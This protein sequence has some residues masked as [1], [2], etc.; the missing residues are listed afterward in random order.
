MYDQYP[1]MHGQC[2]PM[3][4]HYPTM[5][6]QCPP[7]YGQCPPMYGQ[8]PPMHGQ[9]PPLVSTRYPPQCSLHLSSRQWDC[10]RK[11][12]SVAMAMRVWKCTT[13]T[14]ALWSTTSHT[15]TPHSVTLRSVYCFIG[16]HLWWG[17]DNWGELLL[18]IYIYTN[19]FLE[20]YPQVLSVSTH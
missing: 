1:P 11:Q 20:L 9:Y 8:Y 16:A 15:E 4:G 13:P 7:M 6:G 10:R 17:C 12:L 5:H 3:Y 18:S 19:Y 2:P 14:T